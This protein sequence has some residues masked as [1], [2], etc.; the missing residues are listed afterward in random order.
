MISNDAE[1]V[2]EK[3]QHPFMTKKNKNKKSQQTEN[4]RKQSQYNKGI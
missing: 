4:R 1:I 2:F 3:I